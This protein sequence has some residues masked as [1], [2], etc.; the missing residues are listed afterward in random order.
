[1][2]DTLKMKNSKWLSVDGKVFVV[3]DVKVDNK[4]KVWVYY[5]RQHD[6][7]KY[8]CYLNS[9]THRFFKHENY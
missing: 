7:T 5:T 8:H 1:M 3:D 9:F 4:G 6:N 2:N